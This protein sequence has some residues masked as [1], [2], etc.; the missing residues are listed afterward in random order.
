MSVYLVLPEG[1][2]RKLLDTQHVHAWESGWQTFNVTAAIK[3]WALFPLTNHGLKIVIH[4][5]DEELSPRAFGIV[6]ARGNLEKRPYLVGFVRT[7]RVSSSFTPQIVAPSRERRAAQGKWKSPGKTG[8][9]CTL[10]RFYVDFKE[11]GLHNTIIAPKGYDM[12]FCQG[13]CIYPFDSIETTNHAILQSMY[14]LQD[15][16]GAPEPCCVPGGLKSTNLLFF[17]NDQNIVMKDH[18][19]M[20]ATKCVCH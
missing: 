10:K 1:G 9:E 13:L 8:N 15:S 14:N 12:Y 16:S 3:L 2:T 20:V 7:T 6:G 4:H 18:P 5:A 17:D 11:V 19:K